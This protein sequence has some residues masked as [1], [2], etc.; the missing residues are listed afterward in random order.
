M[1][2]RQRSGPGL[3]KRP[4]PLNHDAR[5][6]QRLPHALCQAQAVARPNGKP[7]PINFE[8]SRGFSRAVSGDGPLLTFEFRSRSSSRASR[9]A[10]CRPRD[11][12]VSAKVGAGGLG[13]A[14]EA[15]RST[16]LVAARAARF[17]G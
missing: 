11:T 10:A 3:P 7:R 16:G 14:Y 9:Q 4:D 2:A 15:L 6:P 5:S 1:A 13:R 12:T 17:V 8:A